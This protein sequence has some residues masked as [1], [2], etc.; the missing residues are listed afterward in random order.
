[1]VETKFECLHDTVKTYHFTSIIEVGACRIKIEG[2]GGC[3]MEDTGDV[4]DRK[5]H[6][7]MLVRSSLL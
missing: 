2:S 4:Y 5:L 7:Y 1:M 3:V 6:T